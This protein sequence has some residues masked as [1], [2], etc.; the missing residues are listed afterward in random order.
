MKIGK[1]ISESL[2]TILVWLIGLCIAEFIIKDMYFG[3]KQI[4]LSNEPMV[5][6]LIE[7]LGLLGAYGMYIMIKTAALI[8]IAIVLTKP[9][10]IWCSKYR[11]H[12]TKFIVLSL[13]FT[14]LVVLPIVK[15][16]HSINIVWYDYMIIILFWFSWNTCF[17]IANHVE[18]TI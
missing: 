11:K 13:I 1:N 8:G 4:D 12:L 5:F 14:I 6:G 2:L 17:G 18:E 7:E 15:L 9:Y 10:R 3:M 16:T